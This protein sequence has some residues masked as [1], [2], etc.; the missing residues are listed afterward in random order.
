MSNSSDS[1]NSSSAG[2]AGSVGKMA[3]VQHWNS[4]PGVHF[5]MVPKYNGQ[6]FAEWKSEI[7]SLICLK[8]K[9]MKQMLQ[10][11][12]EHLAMQLKD[13]FHNILLGPEAPEEYW[14]LEGCILKEDI[15]TNSDE[16]VLSIN[17]IKMDPDFNL[18]RADPFCIIREEKTNAMLKPK[19][20]ICIS[21]YVGPQ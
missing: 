10:P 13:L 21:E 19:T 17:G 7:V 18:L 11:D 14:S 16:L 20:E 15:M 12:N 8:E 2:T 9:L 5:K 3:D 6:N 1:S 4:D